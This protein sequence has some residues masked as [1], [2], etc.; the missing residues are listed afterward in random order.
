MYRNEE[1]YW[2][3]YYDAEDEAEREA[4]RDAELA[5]ELQEFDSEEE[6]DEYIQ[7]KFAAEYERRMVENDRNF[8]DCQRGHSPIDRGY[9]W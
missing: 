2:N 1:E 9:Y 8:R 3:D 4:M 5:A 6:R 7:K